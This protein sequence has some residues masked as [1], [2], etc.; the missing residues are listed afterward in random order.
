MTATAARRTALATEH[1][2]ATL[3][4]ASGLDVAL[5]PAITPVWRG[6]I[7]RRFP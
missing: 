3:L 6:A 2:S 5:D 1:T 7:T 4:E